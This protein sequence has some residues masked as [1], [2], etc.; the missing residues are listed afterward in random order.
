MIEASPVNA[1]LNPVSSELLIIAAA[2]V[3]LDMVERDLSSDEDQARGDRAPLGAGDDD[4]LVAADAL[5]AE[6]RKS[7]GLEVRGDEL[8][9]RVVAVVEVEVGHGVDPGR[10]LRRP[11]PARRPGPGRRRRHRAPAIR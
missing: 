8:D 11:R 4:P 6:A 1:G 9:S 3:A 10:E 7:R 2:G 5:A